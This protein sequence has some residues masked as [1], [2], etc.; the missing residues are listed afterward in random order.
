MIDGAREDAGNR[1]PP[2]SRWSAIG[3]R[4]FAPTRASRC[5]STRCAGVT[6]SC[7]TRTG[8]RAPGRRSRGLR[9]HLG[10]PGQPVRGRRTRDRHGHVRARA[11]DPVPRHLRRLPAC[12]RRTGAQPGRDRGGAPC[13]VRAHRHRCDRGTRVLAGRP[14][15]R[16]PLH[17][18]HADRR[19]CGRRAQRRALSLR[20]RDR[21]RL[22]R[23]AGRHLRRPR[24]RRRAPFTRVLAGHPFF[25][26]TLFQPEL[27][28]DGTR[29]HPVIRAFAD[30]VVSR[31]ARAPRPAPER[32][33]TIARPWPIAVPLSSRGGA[34]SSR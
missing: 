10:R 19:D 7:S 17:A 4:A 18:R 9:R 8:S 24:R 11:R 20:F 31:S 5:S 21:A 28:G 2:S 29:A 30:A 32:E 6:A 1:P 33:S 26:G 13:R 15:G 16:D 22:H 25:L 23:P 27:A 34:G 3:R 12:D 14:R